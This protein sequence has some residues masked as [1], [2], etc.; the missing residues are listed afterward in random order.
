MATQQISRGT[1]QSFPSRMR[2]RSQSAVSKTDNI[3][4]SLNHKLL[5]ICVIVLV[6]IWMLYPAVQSLYVANR[7]QQVLTKQLEAYEAIY[8]L[9]QEAN[10]TLTSRE[11]IIDA[12]RALGLVE[13]GEVAVEIEGEIDDTSSDA[14]SES[15]ALE[16]EIAEI[17][18]DSW[19]WY[20]RIGDYI[21][22]FDP[23]EV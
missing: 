7:E 8:E 9:L 5:T 20:I 18:N 11:G 17:V 23:S 2:A 15:L 14:V 3:N 16:E 22:G 12:A 19:P 4:T 13:E 6:G 10:E 1:V 21:F